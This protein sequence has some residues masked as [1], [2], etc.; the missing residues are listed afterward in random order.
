MIYYIVAVCSGMLS[1]MSNMVNTKAGE[2]FGATKGSLINYWGASV[3]SLI[4]IFATGNG[5]DFTLSYMKTVPPLFYLGSVCGLVAL[6]LLVIGTQ[7]KGSSASTILLLFGQLLATIILDYL[8]F[9]KFHIAR[10]LGIFLILVGVSWKEK[11]MNGIKQ[12]E[13]KELA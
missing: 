5:S 4:L 9:G 2:C 13:E 1:S 11:I 8:F 3:A 10:L 7:K 6:V 12:E